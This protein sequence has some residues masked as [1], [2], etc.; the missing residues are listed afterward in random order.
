[1][2]PKR[3]VAGPID[4]R[5]CRRSVAEVILL[6]ASAVWMCAARGADGLNGPFM[7]AGMAMVGW[8]VIRAVRRR[9]ELR[10]LVVDADGVQLGDA[11]LRWGDISEI[12]VVR[13]EHQ[14][15]S[16]SEP[17][18]IGLLPA[19]G[20]GL[21]AGLTAVV[22]ELDPEAIPAQLQLST[23]NWKL[24]ITRL[25]AAVHA[26]G[27]GVPLVEHQGSARRVLA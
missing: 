11:F 24:D 19:A 22:R 2:T 13:R 1:M 26:H 4:I 14:A 23:T 16:G 7:P 9:H 15:T 12:A 6:A 18:E 17:T 3:Y 20:A 5:R 27:C 21:P 25:G 10:A 8:V